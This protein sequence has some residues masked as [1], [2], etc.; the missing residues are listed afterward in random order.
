MIS[1]TPSPS[2]SP[3]PHS[4]CSTD[5][6]TNHQD[7]ESDYNSPDID[8]EKSDW[9][10][11]EYVTVPPHAASGKRRKVVNSPARAIRAAS[12]YPSPRYIAVISETKTV[13]ITNTGLTTCRNLYGSLNWWIKSKGAASSR[14]Q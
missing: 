4:A 8:I 9:T 6:R 5:R 2:Q 12:A 3:G 13:Y 14:Q 1:P 11:T 10:P 7:L